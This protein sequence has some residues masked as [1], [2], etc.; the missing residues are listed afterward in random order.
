MIAGGQTKASPLQES[1]A[2]VSQ[3]VEKIIIYGADAELMAAALNE[4]AIDPL[5][6][7][8]LA[9]AVALSEQQ[10]ESGDTVLLA[11]AATS[12]DQFKNYEERG[13]LFMKLVLAESS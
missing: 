7:N 8:T 2:V 5:R 11:P 1:A 3:Y 4:Q 6:V 9:E 10:A 12:W 13:D